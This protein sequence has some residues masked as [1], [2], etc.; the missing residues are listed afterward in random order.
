MLGIE[1]NTLIIKRVWKFCAQSNIDLWIERDTNM[2]QL[3][4]K[5]ADLWIQRDREMINLLVQ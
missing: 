5:C 3:W 1:L 4:G 2:A